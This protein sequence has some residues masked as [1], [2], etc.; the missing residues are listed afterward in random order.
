MALVLLTAFT[1]IAFAANSLLTRAALGGNQ[2]D[3]LSFTALRLAS[4]ALFL[5]PVAQITSRRPAAARPAAARG[6]AAHSSG[7]WFSGGALFVYALAFSLAYL[8]LSTGTGALILFASVQLTMLGL[9]L[10]SG[11]VLRLGQWLGLTI[12]L[13]GLIYLLLPGLTAPHPL[14][15]ALMGLAGAAWGV[16]S[17]RGRGTAAPILMTAGNFQRAALPALI[18]CVPAFA[19]LRWQLPGVWLALISGMVTSGLGYILW[20][21]ALRELTTTQAAVIQLLVPVLAAV[22]GVLF[23]REPVTVRLV[24]ASLLILGGVALA[25]LWPKPAPDGMS[26]RR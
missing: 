12:A 7:S 10:R 25:A 16:Y 2:I 4:G 20:Y 13:T 23:L 14:G 11:E 3:P 9:A 8:S 22:A 6:L 17:V 15:A 19:T 5:L 26:G 24:I 18:I 21:R 1:L